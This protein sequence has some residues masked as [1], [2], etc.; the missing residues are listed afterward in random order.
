MK[1][2]R[3]L[4]WLGLLALAA[5]L[6]GALAVSAGSSEDPEVTDVAEDSTSNRA[7]HDIVR[8]WITDDNS[9][10]TVSIEA[11]QLDTFSPRDDW[12]TLPT[13]IY[14]YYLTIDEKH[15]AARATIPVHGLL[16]VFA[17]FSLHRGGEE[18]RIQSLRP[19]SCQGCFGSQP[20]APD[21]HMLHSLKQ[22]VSGFW[23]VGPGP[24][25]TGLEMLANPRRHAIRKVI[26]PKHIPGITVGRG[27]GSGGTGGDSIERVA[28]NV[29][30][31]QADHAGRGN[32]AGEPPSL[33]V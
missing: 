30:Q 31:D 14:E 2:A 21:D 22:L 27:V 18:Q 25:Q 3:L 12:R 7:S 11:T 9:T 29:R 24:G 28:D 5:L 16:A 33:D 15:Y 23:G 8:A 13:T 6:V 4:P 17:S 19:G 20:V 32:L 26:L 10:I 1:A